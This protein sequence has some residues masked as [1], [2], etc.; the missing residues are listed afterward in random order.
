MGLAAQ[1]GPLQ[2]VLAE[3]MSVDE[4][5]A[6]CVL[7][8]EGILIYDV[9]LKPIL[10][11]KETLIVF[12]APGSWVLAARVEDDEEW[13]VISCEHATKIRLSSADC[14]I[15]MGQ[16]GVKISKGSE[17]LSQVLSDLITAIKALTVPTSNGPS[18]TPINAAAFDTI[19]NRIT[20]FLK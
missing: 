12:P 8:D 6:T 18:G 5:E 10:S 9:R 4:D 16:N 1:H 15:E 19:K 17:T 13:I 3:V 7:D 11:D 14:V 2:T 20:N